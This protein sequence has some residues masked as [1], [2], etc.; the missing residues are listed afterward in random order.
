MA[1]STDDPLRLL[2]QQ[3]ECSRF[4]MDLSQF[5]PFK[6]PTFAN[7]TNPS[8][9]SHDCDHTAA[10]IIGSPVSSTLV[11]GET[12]YTVV[13]NINHHFPKVIQFRTSALD[14]NLIDKARQTC[15][16]FVPDC[17]PHSMLADAYVYEMDL[18]PGA[19]FSRAMPQLLASGM[20][21]CLVKTVQD[22]ARFFASAWINRPVLELT[23]DT[24]NKLSAHYTW[25]LDQ[26]FRDLPQH[27]HSKLK[28]VRQGLP[29]LFRPDYP[30]VINHDD[31]LE[32]NIHVDEKSGCI[33]S[34]VDWAEAKIAPFG[35]SLWGLETILGVQTASQWIFH[36][37]HSYLRTQF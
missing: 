26:L 11:Q 30:M 2:E 1:P 20:E 4:P 33:T 36:P 8:R 17:K 24:T 32:M 7:G 37:K 21:Q 22:F 23:A 15:G 34:I 14:L 18:V 5:T 31:L 6:L 9:R 28:E 27:F 25:I 19:A 12:S 16:D 29:L 35:T 10:N 3:S 13:A